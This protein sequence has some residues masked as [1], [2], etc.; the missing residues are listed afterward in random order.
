MLLSRLAG[1]APAAVN[2]AF[3]GQC[4]SLGRA[5]GTIQLARPDDTPVNVVLGGRVAAAVK[6]AI[7]KGTV[8]SIRREAAKPGSYFWFKGGK[9]PA[10]VP[11]DDAMVR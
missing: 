8:W 9:R 4:I 10:P 11:V 5:H 3:A 1:T 6:E 2:Q 7:C